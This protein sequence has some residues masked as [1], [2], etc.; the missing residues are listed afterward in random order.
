MKNVLNKYAYNSEDTKDQKFKKILIF[1]IAISCCICGLLWSL[2]YYIVF[3]YG[4]T[5][6]LPLLF[7]IIVGGSILISHYLKMKKF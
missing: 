3:G 5:M 2:S 7:V 4:L 6:L 1:L